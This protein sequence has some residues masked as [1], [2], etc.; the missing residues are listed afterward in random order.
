M[1][2]IVLMD[3]NAGRNFTKGST[4]PGEDIMRNF[5]ILL[6]VF[7]ALS[8]KA[9]AG[10][11]LIS[12]SQAHPATF[13]QT[14]PKV[15][16]APGGQ[17][18]FAWVDHRNGPA[19][20]YAQFMDTA[21]NR[22]GANFPIYGH[23][24]IAFI[25]EQDY[26]STRI[27]EWVIDDYFWEEWHRSIYAQCYIDGQ[28][29]ADTFHVAYHLYPNDGIDYQG[30]DVK[31]FVHNDNYLYFEQNN[32]YP[33]LKRY[34]STGSLLSLLNDFP[35]P[36]HPITYDIHVWPDSGYSIF[37]AHGPHIDPE[38]STRFGIYA[39]H[40]NNRDQ[41]IN[42][43]PEF[44]VSINY[45]FE[46]LLWNYYFYPKI[47]SRSCADSSVQIF[48]W[49]SDSLNFNY[50]IYHRNRGMGSIK[51]IEFPDENFNKLYDRLFKATGIVDGSFALNT[52]GEFYK[53]GSG[54]VYRNYLFYFD[55]DGRYT[56]TVVID[57]IYRVQRYPEMIKT[58][59]RQFVTAERQSNDVYALWLNDFE[60]TDQVKLNDDEYGS[61]QIKPWVTATPDDNFFVTWQDESGGYGQML[62]HEGAAIGEEKP[63]K[64]KSVQFWSDGA[65]LNLW[66]AIQSGT[67]R[68]MLIHYDNDWQ[69]VRTDTIFSA[70]ERQFNKIT[71]RILTDSALVMLSSVNNEITM[72]LTGRD[73]SVRDQLA[74]G[75]LDYTSQLKVFIR[76]SLSFYASWNQYLQLFSNDFQ[77]LSGV[78]SLPFYPHH[79]LAEDCFLHAYKETYGYILKGTIVHVSGDTLAAGIELLN[80]IDDY[81]IFTPERRHFLVVYQTGNRIY[82]RVFRNNGDSDGSPILI[83]DDEQ[84]VRTQPAAASNGRE[85]LFAWSD[86][87]IAERG[88]SVFGNIRP[89]SSLVAIR[90]KASSLLKNFTLYQNYPNPF[91]QQTVIEYDLPQAAF[92]SLQIYDLQGRLIQT[93][94]DGRQQSGRHAVRWDGLNERGQAVASGIYFYRLVQKSGQ[95][96]SAGGPV[97]GRMILLR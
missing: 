78:V 15:F 60:V 52:R 36:F 66:Q 83:S 22:I 58:A 46:A 23:E 87:R 70:P 71:A 41:L 30:W 92:I 19:G 57:S 49:E 64:S 79:Y 39:A 69:I 93:L 75:S 11:F 56:E 48:Y 43:E 4:L 74:L 51:T 13:V 44:L 86:N 29:S 77:P 12:A 96:P 50:F 2:N 42:V 80:N 88:Y 27:K 72:T 16:Q 62:S 47:T 84:A 9:R 32:G 7:S 25:S 34:N 38:D 37:Y 20:H 76:D 61:N 67:F 65:A 95:G 53:S 17:L 6:V 45:D 10:D 24:H 14:K 1:I 91:N 40:F 97:I 81:Y 28:P 82:T 54:D 59:E 5:I 63:L 55:Q 94:V 73:G 21:G 26:I 35:I 8:M 33:L 68:L 85:V 3:R 18:L 31:F 90:E 89:L